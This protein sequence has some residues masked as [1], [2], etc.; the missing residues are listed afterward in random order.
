[1]EDTSNMDRLAKKKL[2]QKIRNRMSAQRSRMRKGIHYQIVENENKFL[3]KKLEDF[4]LQ[5][6]RLIYEK[7]ILTQQNSMMKKEIEE[8]KSS[9]CSRWWEFF[10]RFNLKLFC[11][12]PR[13]KSYKS[14]E[15]DVLFEYDQKYKTVLSIGPLLSCN[16]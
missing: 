8:L 7:E 4:S 11:R 2:I 6:D 10:L 14:N 12:I 1:M 16:E 9:G 5:S 13:Y 3:R 15:S